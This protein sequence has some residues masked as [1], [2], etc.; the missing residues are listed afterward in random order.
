MPFFFYDWKD[1]QPL[2]LSLSQLKLLPIILFI[3]LIAKGAMLPISIVYFPF[4]EVEFHCFCIL[5]YPFCLP[6]IAIALY[7]HYIFSYDAFALYYDW[8]F[9]YD[10]IAFDPMIC[11]HIYLDLVS[12]GE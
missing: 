9:S 1:S 2:S 3:E 8:I 4:D 10:A 12:F 6:L 11:A 5:K 7:S